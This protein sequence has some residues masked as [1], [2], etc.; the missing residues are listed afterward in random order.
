[1]G[2]EDFSRSSLAGRDS[3]KR[4]SKPMKDAWPRTQRCSNNSALEHKRSITSFASCDVLK[5]QHDV[6]Q[7]N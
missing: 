1:M 6:I 3:S 7:R 4:R 2:L 5:S